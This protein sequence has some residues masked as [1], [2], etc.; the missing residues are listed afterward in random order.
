[1]DQGCPCLVPPPQYRIGS[2][3]DFIPTTA[4]PKRQLANSGPPETDSDRRTTGPVAASA[5]SDGTPAGL[6]TRH[7]SVHAG[8]DHPRGDQLLGGLSDILRIRCTL[9]ANPPG[10]VKTEAGTLTFLHLMTA[11]IIEFHHSGFSSSVGCQCR[12]RTHINETETVTCSEN[13]ELAHCLH[14]DVQ[15]VC[16]GTG[17]GKPSLKP[18]RPGHGS[19]RRSS[20]GRALVL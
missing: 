12:G 6:L 9:R 16:C 11:S 1:M 2:V 8:R 18:I 15:S 3:V 10:G 14:Y 5:G 7:G 13:L 4:R 19:G 17:G 20:I